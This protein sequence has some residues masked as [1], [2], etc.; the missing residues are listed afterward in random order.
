[1]FASYRLATG[2]LTII[3]VRPPTDLGRRTARNA[4]LVAPLAVLPISILA[5]L[6][7]WG[8]LLLGLPSALAGVVAVALLVLGTRA[9]HL[10]GLADTVDALGSARERDQALT[11]MKSGDIGP[12]GVAALIFTGLA[13]VLAAGVLL[14]RPWGWLEF[15]VLV[16]ASRAALALGCLT[17]VPAAREEGL[18]AMVAGSVPTPAA[19]GSWLVVGG[20]ATAAAVLATQPFWVPITAVMVAVLLVAWLI[21][22]ATKRFGGI[23]GDVLGAAVELAATMLLLV[24][25]IG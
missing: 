23:T 15:A 19:V 14:G 22:L 7:G 21:Q 12:M 13:Q 20:F 24:S 18:G 2:L 1:M 6:T 17:G 16:A 4:M 3:P 8:G 11:I 25:A 9:M 10:D 5:G